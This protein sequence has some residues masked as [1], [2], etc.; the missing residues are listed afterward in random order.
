MNG[1]IVFAAGLVFAVIGLG[2]LNVPLLVRHQRTTGSITGMVERPSAGT[3]DWNSAWYSFTPVYSFHDSEG[4]LRSGRSGY[5][6]RDVGE[7]V[8]VIYDEDDSA[9]LDLLE[10]IGPLAFLGVGGLVMT[11]AWRGDRENRAR[12]RE[13]RLARRDANLVARQRQRTVNEFSPIVRGAVERLAVGLERAAGRTLLDWHAVTAAESAR[14]VALWLVTETD[15]DLA[16]LTA[17]GTTALADSIL[18]GE[19][20]RGGFPADAARDLFIG[21]KSREELQR[22]LGPDFLVAWPLEPVVAPARGPI[23]DGPG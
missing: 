18:R 19:L 7:I 8:T 5:N 9:I 11:L 14:E 23:R 4:N 20:V 3:Q 16:R 6:D 15:A 17:S 22:H 13:A 21:F 10:F 2:W 12:R 1:R